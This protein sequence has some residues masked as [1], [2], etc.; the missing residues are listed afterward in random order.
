MKVIG[1]THH[2]NLVRLLGYCNDGPQ[3]HLVYEYMVNGS[4]ANILF[5]PQHQP[6]WDERIRIALEI[7]RG[8]LYLHEECP[9]QIIH[10]D[11]KPQ[12]ILIDKDMLAKFSD[13]GLARLLKADQ[14]NTSTVDIQAP[15]SLRS[16]LTAV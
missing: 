14:T 3:K 7:A 10:C 13:F 4:L 11:I 6:R 2:R 16:Y 5:D 1:K 12:N 9:T 15:P 8:I